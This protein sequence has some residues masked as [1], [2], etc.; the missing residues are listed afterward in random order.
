MPL[1]QARWQI[2]ILAADKTAQAFASVDRRMKSL[3]TSTKTSAASLANSGSVGASAFAM[4]NRAAVPLLG[5]LSAVSIAHR[6]W[7]AGMKSGALID[8]AAQLGTTTEALQAFRLVAAQSGVATEEFDGAL[9]RL[10]GQ[11]GQAAGG[12]DEA[13][14]KFDRLGVKLLDARGQL[15]PI[16]DLLPEVARGLQGVSSETERNA[17]AQELFGRSG[18]RIVT[19]LGTLAQ[20][21]DAVTAAARAQNAVVEKDSLE[22]WNKL[23]AQL[24]V[25]SVSADAALASLGAPIATAALEIVNRILT[26]INAN[27]AKLKL[28][29]QTAGGRA[30]GVDVAHLEEQLAAQRNLLGINPNN[31]MAQQSAAA[32]ERRLAEAR[33]QQQAAEGADAAG[34]Y[35]GDTVRFTGTAGV[36]QPV[37]NAAKKAASGGAGGSLKEQTDEIGAL[38]RKLE[39][40]GVA[41]T[42]RF[43]DG[44]AYAAR[45]TAELNALLAIGAISD[46]THAR[47]LQD[48]TLKS[49]D[50]ARAFR[51]AA[52]G[53]GGFQS[54][55]E[56]GLADM[57]RA[58]TAF[59]MG[60]Q[61][62]DQMADSLT[63]LATGAEVDF[64]RILQSFLSMLIQMEIRAA[65]S[66]IFNAISGKGPTDSGIG[67]MLAGLFGGAAGSSAGPIS[68]GGIPTIAL[69]GGGDYQAGQIRL[70]GEHGPEVDFTRQSGRVMNR[71]QLQS[72]MGGGNDGRVIV[73]QT[74]HVGEF[75]TSTEFRRGL[76]AVKQAAERGAQAAFLDDR[77][78]GGESKTAFG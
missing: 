38:L 1:D 23:D 37:G 6:T 21:T 29:G 4:I 48:V 12:S 69:A 57:A 46:G 41:V 9:Q 56:Q 70:V 30:A 44:M 20:G 8:Q 73:Y 47:A 53:W 40:D 17:L 75:V 11:V 27:L 68:V 76:G 66:N 16:N 62:V 58:N 42:D 49:D 7:T 24:K 39:Q 55:L 60:R 71:D 74:V 15:R 5:I 25:T 64:N 36:G 45:E 3:E 28:E 72:M 78:R 19:M 77:R 32:L 31:K 51:G 67:G 33:A 2:D 54:G 22:A 59:E 14:A 26:D 13:I 43:G 34:I 52:G 63:D 65:A 18:A 61:L 10:T 35:V 50:M